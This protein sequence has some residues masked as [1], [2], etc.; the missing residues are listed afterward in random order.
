MVNYEPKMCRE[1]LPKFYPLLEILNFYYTLT[2][3]ASTHLS[4]DL[5]HVFKFS[6]DIVMT[7]LPPQFRFTYIY[8]ENG[9]LLPGLALGNIPGL[10]QCG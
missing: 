4:S 1:G 8:K 9:R 3:I 6:A 10:S 5:I 2:E 7:E